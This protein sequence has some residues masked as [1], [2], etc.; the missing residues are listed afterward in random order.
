MRHLFEQFLTSGG[1][2]HA[3]AI[4][5]NVR[6]KK[7]GVRHGSHVWKK[8]EL[9]VKE[10]LACNDTLKYHFIAS[11]YLKCQVPDQCLPFNQVM[12]KQSPRIFMMKS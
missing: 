9:L 7:R 4:M 11:N 12:A 1:D 6:S 10:L 8:F 2:W 5:L 3:T